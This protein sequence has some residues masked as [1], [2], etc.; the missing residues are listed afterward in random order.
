M[1]SRIRT[2]ASSGRCALAGLIALAALAPLAAE[3]DKAD[4]TLNIA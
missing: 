3:A 1:F 2:R 4:D